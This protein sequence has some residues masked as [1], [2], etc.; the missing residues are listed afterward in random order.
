M[1]GVKEGFLDVYHSEL[2]LTRESQKHLR[3]DATHVM[4]GAS[5]VGIGGSLKKHSGPK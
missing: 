1:L 4:T 5:L 3:E 2:V